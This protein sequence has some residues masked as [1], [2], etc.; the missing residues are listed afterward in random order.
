MSGSRDIVKRFSKL[1]SAPYW[2]VMY[3]K[4]NGVFIYME[5]KNLNYPLVKPKYYYSLCSDIFSFIKQPHDR[6]DREKSTKFKVY[7]TVGLYLLKF[8]FLIPVVLFFAFV[9]D[10]DNIQSA[11]MAE[12]FSPAILLMV[13]GI[14]LPFF[15][16]I[17][18]RLSLVFK[19]VYLA[20]SSSVCTYY[21]LTKAVFSTKISMVDESFMSRLIISVSLGAL[22]YLIFN[23]QTIKKWLA[24]FWAANFRGIFYFV[25]IV[26]AW[27][28]I[29]KYEIT[30]LNV[31]LLPILTMPQLLSAI[32]YGYIRLSFG[33]IY[34]LMLHIG[35]NTAVISISILI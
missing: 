17:G 6:R 9:Y 2:G 12:R 4:R 18:F 13:G 1:L 34:P 11:S 10:P 31:L 22:L 7:D 5:D 21:F 8:L 25:C 20:L 19:P 26:F 30:L 28:H 24:S 15:E 35:M 14:L 23:I 3:L 32:I 27:M 33:F 29:T 16:E